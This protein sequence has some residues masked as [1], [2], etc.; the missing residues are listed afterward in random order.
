M[1]RINIPLYIFSGSTVILTA[2]YVYFRIM[3]VIEEAINRAPSATS[4]IIANPIG[5]L[6]DLIPAAIVLFIIGFMLAYLRS[7]NGIST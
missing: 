4:A 7:S 3:P 5:F 2:I 1:N 6:I